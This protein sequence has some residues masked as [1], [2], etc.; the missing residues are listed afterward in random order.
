VEFK[1]K[2]A[3]KTTKAYSGLLGCDMVSLHERF[4]VKGQADQ[5]EALIFAQQST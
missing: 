1:L 2:N 4:I 3:T 5:Q